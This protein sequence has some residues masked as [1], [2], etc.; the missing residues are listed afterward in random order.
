VDHPTLTQVDVT[1]PG[2]LAVD[3]Q[4]AGRAVLRQVLEQVGQD[5]WT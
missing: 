3:V 5:A 1:D 4:P 2:A